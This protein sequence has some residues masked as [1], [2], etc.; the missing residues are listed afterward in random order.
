[1]PKDEQKGGLNVLWLNIYGEDLEILK[2]LETEGFYV[3]GTKLSLDNREIIN[4]EWK[5]AI[6]VIV[7]SSVN[8]TIDKYIIDNFKRLQ[9]IVTRSTGCEHINL[10][11]C[12]N[13]GIKVCSIRGYS[14]ISTAEY[15]ISLIFSLLRKLKSTILKVQKGRFERET[16]ADLHGKIVGVVG[17]GLVG[18]TVAKLLKCLGAKVFYWSFRRKEELEGLGIRYVDLEELYR[19]ADVLTFHLS[20]SEK[21]R[22]IFNRGSLRIVK[23]GVYIV[24]TARGGLIEL[25][26]IYEGLRNGIIAGCALDCFEGESYFIR[27]K[28]SD[29]P[30]KIQII[31]DIAKFPNVIITPHN[32]YNSE[33]SIKRDVEYTLRTLLHYRK[34]GECLYPC[35]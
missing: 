25:E 2:N 8:T 18:T 28:S 13:K 5:D 16:G 30:S 11:Y 26:A 32:A 7:F 21:T 31:N 20:L 22:Y 12:N 24:N 29:S 23:P 19:S 34:T 14:T 35:Q 6:D 9:L 10:E 27:G 15:T 17:T 33:E 1:M 4:L 3:Y